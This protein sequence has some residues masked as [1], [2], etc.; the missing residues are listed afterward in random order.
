MKRRGVY[1]YCEHAAPDDADPVWE[2]ACPRWRRVSR[3]L[4]DRYTAIGGK[5]PPPAVGG[6]RCALCL[7]LQA[8]QG[9]VRQGS[10]HVD[11]ATQIQCGRGLAPDGGVSADI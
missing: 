11:Q 4:I 10:G 1:L 5:P 7:G 8:I 9:E 2:G 6:A 3:H